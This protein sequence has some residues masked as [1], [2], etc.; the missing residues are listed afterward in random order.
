MFLNTKNKYMAVNQYFKDTISEMKHV[1]WPT[2]RQTT[3][4]TILV[5]VVSIIISA[6]LGLLDAAFVKLL[7][8]F[9][10]Q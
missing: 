6:Y 1:S 7:N 10:G 9:I 4:Y 2:R 5:I 8:V 3:L